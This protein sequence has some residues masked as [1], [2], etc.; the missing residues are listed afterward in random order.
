MH[1]LCTTD[2][3]NKPPFVYCPINGLHYTTL[4]WA[5]EVVQHKGELSR[6]GNEPKNSAN[7][8]E[9]D[10]TWFNG[11]L[12]HQMEITQTEIQKKQSA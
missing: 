8:N 12:A 5:L 7:Y 2:D 3:G 6:R 4:I 9:E 10:I 11:E 1:R